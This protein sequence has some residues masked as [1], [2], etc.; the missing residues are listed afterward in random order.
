MGKTEIK[1]Y[2]EIVNKLISDKEN[3][4]KFDEKYIELKNFIL[5]NYKKKCSTLRVELYSRLEELKSFAKHR[6]TNLLLD[7]SL[8]PF[9]YEQKATM[10]G[11]NFMKY[12]GEAIRK[13]IGIKKI[14]KEQGL[15]LSRMIKSSE[16]QNVLI[17][18]LETYNIMN[19]DNDDLHDEYRRLIKAFEKYLLEL[20]ALNDMI[21][22]ALTEEDRRA[23]DK[24]WELYEENEQNI[25]QL[26]TQKEYDRTI[27]MVR[28]NPN[29][30]YLLFNFWD[31]IASQNNFYCKSVKRVGKPN[32]SKIIL[33]ILNLSGM[34]F[35]NY[36]S[37]EFKKIQKRWN[38]FKNKAK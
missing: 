36:K 37:K 26:F 25:I 17:R 27:E 7:K 13:T 34:K 16:N 2:E 21:N 29:L 1:D 4:R 11:L 35:K 3:N 14:S 28:K 38:I 32:D 18:K 8:F 24:I 31:E 30:F 6:V 23:S 19:N 15:S 10:T 12:F 9:I 5:N 33:W 20:P 22:K